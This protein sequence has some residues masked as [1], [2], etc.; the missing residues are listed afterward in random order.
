MLKAGFDFFESGFCYISMFRK[1][2]KY[3]YMHNLL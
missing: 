1:I 2:V 3:N